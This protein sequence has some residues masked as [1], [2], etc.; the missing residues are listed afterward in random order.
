MLEGSTPQGPGVFIR[1]ELLTVVPVLTGSS[2]GTIT[3]RLNADVVV[4]VSEVEAVGFEVGLVPVES[5]MM[6]L[7]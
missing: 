2:V 4:Q 5:D 7:Q 6:R 3:G 1:P